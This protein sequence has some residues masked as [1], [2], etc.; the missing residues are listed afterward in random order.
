MEEIVYNREKQVRNSNI[1]LLRIIMMIAII[2]HHYVVNSG[3]TELYNFNNLSSNMIFLQI[4]GFAGKAMINGFLLISGYFMVNKKT[5][6]KK[7]I[8]LYLQIKIYTILIFIIMYLLGFETLSAS[9]IIKIIFSI[10]KNVNVGFSA[11]FFLLYLI[12]PFINKFVASI[13][14]K[15]FSVLLIILFVFYTFIPT[16]LIINDTFDELGWYIT[17]YLM[18]AYIKLYLDTVILSIRK[19]F[20]LVLNN[21]ILI[22][23]SILFF[24]TIKFSPYHMVINANKFLAVSL[25]ISLFIAF[26]NI[27]IG[28]V[29]MINT[30]S[31]ATF[32]VLLIHANSEAMRTFLW[33]NLLSVKSYYNSNYLILHAILSVLSIYIICTLIELFRIKF[34]EMPILN[35]VFKTNMFNKLEKN[36][37]SIW[38]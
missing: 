14:K 7:I 6:L 4:F 2:A 34:I 20:V 9:S 25:A 19:S 22:V 1:E 11:T 37:K 32:G 8:R 18:G 15:Q 26:K 35:R 17:M 36:Y 13:N 24:D 10:V 28:Y 33:E 21:L 23:V 5:S 30:L 38:E 29:K 31:S 12:M 27:N 3:I 16:F